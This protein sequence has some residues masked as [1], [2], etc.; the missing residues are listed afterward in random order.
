MRIVPVRPALF[1]RKHRFHELSCIVKGEFANNSEVGSFSLGSHVREQFFLG[2]FPRDTQA[3]ARRFETKQP[4]ECKDIPVLAVS[5]IARQGKFFCSLTQHA[6]DAAPCQVWQAV[7]CKKGK[8]ILHRVFHTYAGDK[9][10]GGFGRDLI[11]IL[12]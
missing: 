2:Q 7:W 6:L 9:G 11:H 4:P 8:A 10:R 1:G 3:G 5:K 12:A